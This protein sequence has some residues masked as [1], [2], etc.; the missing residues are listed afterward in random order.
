M[1]AAMTRTRRGRARQCD[2]GVTR[3]GGLLAAVLDTTAGIAQRRGLRHG[4]DVVT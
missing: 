2:N 3:G 4:D 1:R